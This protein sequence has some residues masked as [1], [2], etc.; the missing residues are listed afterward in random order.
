MMRRARHVAAFGKMINAYK[1]LVGKP[2]VKRPLGRQ[3][4]KGEDNI[5][6]GCENVSRIQL[7]LDRVQ[8]RAFVIT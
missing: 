6:L 4:D 7:F 8:R 1:N 5:E 3:R 2:Y